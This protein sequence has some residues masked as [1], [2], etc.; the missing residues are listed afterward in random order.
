MIL[1]VEMNNT[2][3]SSTVKVQE[4][5]VVIHGI[6]L[7]VKHHLSFIKML[8][9]HLLKKRVVPVR[10][11]MYVIVRVVIVVRAVRMMKIVINVSN[12]NVKMVRLDIVLVVMEV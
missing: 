5:E 9:V 3:I 11:N 1:S 6:L 8:T 4:R 2:G 7:I 10:P 12:Q